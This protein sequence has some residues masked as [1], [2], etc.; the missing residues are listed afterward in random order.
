MAV[1]ADLSA[2]A[3][4][5]ADAAGAV[6]RKYWRTRVEVISKDARLDVFADES[7]AVDADAYEELR[8]GDDFFD[9]TA[10]LFFACA[11]TLRCIFHEHVV[12]LAL[13]WWILPAVIPWW[14]IVTLFKRAVSA[15][16]RDA[17]YGGGVYACF[18]R[19]GRGR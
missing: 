13:C 9:Y 14:L 17:R 8:L 7:R 4:E 15:R 19:A 16:R 11:I 1:P 3:D 6:I 2:F 18:V 10:W 12:S 5:L